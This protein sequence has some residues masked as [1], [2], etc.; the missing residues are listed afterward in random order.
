M[1][2]KDEGFTLDLKLDLKWA[3]NSAQNGPSNKKTN[4]CS[5][6]KNLLQIGQKC[7]QNGRMNESKLCP[8]TTWVWTFD[9]SSTILMIDGKTAGVCIIVA[10]KNAI[11]RMFDNV[12]AQRKLISVQCI[13]IRDEQTN[14][15]G[16]TH[17]IFKMNFQLKRNTEYQHIAT[18]T[19]QWSKTTE[20]KKKNTTTRSINTKMLH[21]CIG[22]LGLCARVRVVFFFTLKGNKNT[23]RQEAHKTRMA[24]KEQKKESKMELL[25]GR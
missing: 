15:N 14:A 5:Y 4:F 18:Q 10:P 6:E 3:A 11:S 9:M 19:S 16:T 1:D 22:V 21:M 25:Y 17:N 2:V 12:V 7:L 8:L 23:A 13:E 20:I 24:Q